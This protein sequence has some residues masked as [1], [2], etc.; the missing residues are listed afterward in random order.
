MFD[1]V[2]I[3]FHINRFG[4]FINTRDLKISYTQTL[5]SSH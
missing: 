3:E 5:C 1:L 2:I 4:Y